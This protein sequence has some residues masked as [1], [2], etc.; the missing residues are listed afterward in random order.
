MA[1][2]RGPLKTP[3]IKDNAARIGE[4]VTVVIVNDDP[5]FRR[6]D[7]LAALTAEQKLRHFR[8]GPF[9]CFCIRVKLQ[10]LT[11]PT[12]WLTGIFF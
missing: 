10:G 11:A 9:D 5:V 2:S 4:G 7:G 1:A 6:S 12:A 8:F 3:H